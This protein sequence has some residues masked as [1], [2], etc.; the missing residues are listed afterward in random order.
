MWSAVSSLSPAAFAGC[1]HLRG[2]CS[3]EINASAGY[4]CLIWAV[5]STEQKVLLIQTRF[6]NLLYSSIKACLHTG[7]DTMGPDGQEWCHA[8]GRLEPGLERWLGFVLVG[9]WEGPYFERLKVETT[10]DVV[11]IFAQEF[12]WSWLAGFNQLFFNVKCGW[13]IWGYGYWHE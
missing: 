1:Q 13:R 2:A 8:K 3:H 11:S 9:Q 4:A 12:P 6:P 5:V 10:S 7:Q